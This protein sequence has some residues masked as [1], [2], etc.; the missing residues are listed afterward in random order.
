MAKLNENKLKELVEAHNKGIVLGLKDVA[1]I[2]PRLD[3]DVLLHD[4]PKTF[5]LYVLAFDELQ[6]KSD[7]NDRMGYFQIAGRKELVQNRHIK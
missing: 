2:V 6:Q 1:G 7:I 5:N 3:I 4:Y